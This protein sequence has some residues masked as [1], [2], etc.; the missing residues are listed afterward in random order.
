MPKR[1]LAELLGAERWCVMLVSRRA[2]RIFRGTRERLVE[3]TD[4]L[5]DVHRRIAAGGWS[6]ARYQRGIEHE[7]DEH[8]R[9]TDRLL[10]EHWQRR[11]FD[12]LLIGGPRELHER[13]EQDLQAELRKRLS[14]T[15][16]IDVE[17]SLADEVHARALPE[18]EDSEDQRERLALERVREGLGP[19]GHAAT[20]ADDALALLNDGRVRTLMLVPGFAAPGVRC[21]QCG[22]MEVSADPAVCPTDGAALETVEDIIENAVEAALAQDAEVLVFRHRQEELAA[23]GSIAVLLRY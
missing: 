3:V 13:V 5:D 7:V 4:V 15:F 1:P 14:G 20:G 17:R 8:I 23:D 6:Q 2:S 10:F 22:W 12:H 19:G 21:P 18:I 9:G 11:R 16:E